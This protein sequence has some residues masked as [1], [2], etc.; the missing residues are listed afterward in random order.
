VERD[1]KI[2][3][4]GVS[5]TRVLITGVTGF[6]GR[7]LAQAL[8]ASKYTVFGTCYPQPPRDAEKHFVFLDLRSER[9]VYD[10]VRSVQPQW[11]FHL[12]AVSNVRQSWSRRKET[13]ET[14]VMGTFYLL[15]AVK[16]YAPGAR[17]LFVSSSDV[18]G[19]MP[20]GG[21]A[22]GRPLT[23]DEPFHL[24][25]P[26]G[27]SKFKGELLCGFYGRIDGLDIVIARPFPHTGPG[28]A[29]DFVCSDWARQVIRIERG[30]QESV[31]KVG[32]LDI[33]RD[34]TDVRDVVQAYILLMLKGGRGEVYNICRGEAVALRW[35]LDVLLSHT[36]RAIDVEQDPGKMRPVDI[37][38]HAGDN[39][40][41]RRATGWEPKIPLEQ[42][43]RELLDYWRA[44]P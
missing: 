19:D 10:A 25:N 42:T 21:G 41:V 44:H 8:P 7:H 34:F 9:D 29:P 5:K 11:V 31:L 20:A 33:R 23:E 2:G 6:A 35:I 39:S 26:Y 37:S 18:Y 12:A 22:A 43:L 4:K 1:G 24:I 28:Q 38:Y 36:A 40:K 14:N 17:V 32:N 27:L 30:A 3:F 13:M 15:E 16:K